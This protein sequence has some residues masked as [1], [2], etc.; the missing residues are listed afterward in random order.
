MSA[1]CTLSKQL[2][3]L[4]RVTQARVISTTRPVVGRADYQG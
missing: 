2:T 1:L 3:L 4:N